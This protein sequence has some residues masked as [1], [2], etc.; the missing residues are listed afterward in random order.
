MPAA[1]EIQQ[2]VC[3]VERASRAIEPLTFA[4]HGPVCFP[5]S[6]VLRAFGR[7]KHREAVRLLDHELELAGIPDDKAYA[8][9]EVF[10]GNITLC[11]F[12]TMPTAALRQAV[13]AFEH[14]FLGRYSVRTM[15]LV[16][17]DEVCTSRSRAIHASFTI[18][19]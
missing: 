6:V 15:Q 7:L 10:I 12:T 8:S 18:G 14:L 11:R 19:A 9:D 13:L 16:Q 17:C 5:T 1:Q 2:A 4:I 3:A